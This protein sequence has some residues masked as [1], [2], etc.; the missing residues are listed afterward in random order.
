MCVCVCLIGPRTVPHESVFKNPALTLQSGGGGGE[1]GELPAAQRGFYIVVCFCLTVFTCETVTEEATEVHS[2]CE[3][4]WET[5][6][7]TGT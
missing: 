1:G 2:L 7:A 4:E 6:C 5:L 3:R